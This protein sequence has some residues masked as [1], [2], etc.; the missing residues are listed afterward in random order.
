LQAILQQAAEADARVIL[1]DIARLKGP[2]A[3]DMAA[4]VEIAGQ[5]FPRMRLVLVHPE[6][7]ARDA[8]KVGGLACI[9]DVYA[10]VDAALESRDIRRHLLP[11]VRALVLT[12]R[13]KGD[14]APLTGAG[15]AA[16]LDFLGRPIVSRVMDH[17]QS[18]GVRDVILASDERDAALET[19]V[20]GMD[21]RDLSLL[22]APVRPLRPTRG[23]DGHCD[24]LRQL[25]AQMRIL[26]R[27]L[28]IIDGAQLTNLDLAAMMREH[29]ATG[30]A[31]TVAYRSM[32]AEDADG[33]AV[34]E[35]D[36]SG[37]LKSMK[38][39]PAHD[40]PHDADMGIYIVSP[41]VADVNWSDGTGI[42]EGLIPR[43]LA[44][45]LRVQGFGQ[46]YSYVPVRTPNE[47]LAALNAALW[48]RIPGITPVGEELAPGQWF[49]PTA[50]VA[51]PGQI[52][53]RIWA[54]PHVH[55]GA[56]ARVAGWAILQERAKVLDGA[57]VRNSL[58]CTNTRATSGAVFDGLCVT[59]AA[60]YT[61]ADRAFRP[62]IDH[63]PARSMLPPRDTTAA[64]Q[65]A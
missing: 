43:L 18:F 23:R 58:L 36:A 6:V 50:T 63:R 49:H 20:R 14:M 21:G 45:G 57:Y 54:G 1:L 3:S 17:L 24:I 65:I 41:A 30:A 27:P 40:L 5:A 31:L 12:G 38:T 59:R 37:R 11:H 16:G 26:S 32:P 28:I 10:S 46:S 13:G 64:G 33:R 42:G 61:T 52:Q 56:R 62:V 15:S 48:K 9:L 51:R 4:L 34:L 44:E 53:G 25:Q 39:G 2:R 7:R 19:A 22:F 55:I 60:K 47:Y 29:V 35:T 8:L